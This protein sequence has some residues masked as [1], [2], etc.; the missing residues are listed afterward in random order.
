M[1]NFHVVSHT[2]WDREWYQTFEEFRRRLV[3]LIDHLLD[4]YR[5]NPEY[6]YL[7]DAQTVCLEDYLELRP[8]RRVE[9]EKHIRSG[10]LL[11]GPWY[12]QNDFFLTSGEATV[13][14]LLIGSEIAR[15]FGRCGNI[16]Y[17]PDQFGLI[18]QLPQILRGFGIDTCV[19]GRG[20]QR[21]QK[22]P[23][24]S[25]A[26]LRQPNEFIWFSP[27]GSSVLSSFLSH[28]YNNAQ[29]FSANPESAMSFLRAI[30]AAQDGLAVTSH[31]LLMNGVD[32]LEA[33][34]DLLPILEE[35]A[36]GLSGD[37]RI[38]Q[39]T[40]NAYFDGVKQELAKGEIK[41]S[42]VVGEMRE[43]SSDQLLQGT[44]SAWVSLKQQNVRAQAM[45]EQRLE[46]MRA[47]LGLW[48]GDPDF[49]DRDDFR[50][51]WKS[52]LKNHP[53]DSI[54]GCSRDLVHVDNLN[55]FARLRAASD[56]LLKRS[57]SALF[58]RLDRSG[59]NPA[60]Y[61]LAVFNHAPAIASAVIEAKLYLPLDETLESV[62]IIDPAGEAQDF[63]ITR[64][65]KR[66]RANFPAINLPGKTACLEVDILLAVKNL[67]A[68]GYRT[69]IVQAGQGRKL[70]TPLISAKSPYGAALENEFLTA[71][72]DVRGR[73]S[74][75]DKQSGETI[76][77]CLSFCDESD[78]GH[79]YNFFPAPGEKTEILGDIAE[80]EVETL[81]NSPLRQQALIRLCCLL[82][83]EYEFENKRR[84]P[85]QVP[86]TLEIVC[87]LDKGSRRLDI[88]ICIDNQAFE[89]RLRA[90]VRTGIESDL[91]FASVPFGFEQ[92]SCKRSH[93]GTRHNG[94]EPNCGVIGISDGAKSFTVFNEGLFEYEHL[95]GGAVALTLLRSVRRIT[96]N[97]FPFQEEFIAE[98]YEWETPGTGLSGKSRIKLA[99]RPGKATLAK[100]A[101]EYQAFICPPDCA[102][103]SVDERKFLS[104]RPFEQGSAVG[105]LFFRQLAPEARRLQL[106]LPGMELKGE[107]VF[108]ALKMAEDGSG[109][110]LRVYNPSEKDTAMLS[111]KLP[112][113]IAKAVRTELDES[114]GAEI[115][116]IDGTV[117]LELRA[118]EIVSIRLLP[119]NDKQS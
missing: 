22:G 3:D 24:G 61:L 40:L 11:V 119:V 88:E 102:F 44:L 117:S 53:H 32:H 31:R 111:I 21:F 1:K 12:V 60:D 105:E 106:E 19:F 95:D 42:R 99:L 68:F 5:K 6:I 14:N 100:L 18:G 109:L 110:I 55:R 38:G 86:L 89:H 15:E 36:A 35:L 16:G 70:A 58:E 28:W 26:A 76:Q 73:L 118:A 33:Q 107:V 41:L 13:R 39:S 23:D 10:H 75:F 43:G 96:D 108:S 92:R 84:S 48:I 80:I 20:Y 116:I 49:Y 66:F 65:Q 50:F 71:S 67:P 81:L 59:L 30:D 9:L 94:D 74:L 90:I 79:S 34:E 113:A 93:D 29:R 97:D 85:R 47:M 25:L 82:P 115:A 46:P 91:T 45:L 56:D 7:L 112:A 54:C 114:D 101:A 87:T 98:A 37:E 17:A 83:A 64:T 57:F 69:Y 51:L 77:N 104:G 8:H 78:I 52:L 72:I 2:H 27:D 62:R 103:D 4:I 63:V